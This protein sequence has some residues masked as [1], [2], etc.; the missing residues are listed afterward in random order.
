MEEN[1]RK[2]V[3]S[4][5]EW[6]ENSC[7]KNEAPSHIYISERIIYSRSVERLSAVYTYHGTGETYNLKKRKETASRTSEMTIK[8]PWR[9]RTSAIE[10]PMPGMTMTSPLM[11][12]IKLSCLTGYS[13]VS[14]T[15]IS[16]STLQKTSETTKS[17]TQGKKRIGTS[18]NLSLIRR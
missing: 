13:R 2:K 10:S 4:R 11:L 1:R 8:C 3:G 17:Y 14:K 7:R 12:I 9:K 5:S 18:S 16:N 6:E 15:N